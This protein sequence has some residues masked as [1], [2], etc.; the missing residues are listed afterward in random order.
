MNLEKSLKPPSIFTRIF[1]SPEET[2]L[3]TGWRLLLQTILLVVLV[4]LLSLVVYLP[5][6]AF[7]LPV[8][9]LLFGQINEFITISLSVFLARRFLDRR[10]FS[11]LGFK[12][13]W[14]TLA[15]LFVGII[16]SATMMGLI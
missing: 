15:D 4:V 12:I 7:G 11:S 1:L 16:I 6:S 10:S 2:R 8:D 14:Q 13:N 3:R 5:A 9:S